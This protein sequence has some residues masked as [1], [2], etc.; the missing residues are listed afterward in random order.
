MLTSSPSS[1]TPSS[2]SMFHQNLVQ[3]G[4]AVPPA[5]LNYISE[6]DNLIYALS[7]LPNVRRLTIYKQLP[8]KDSIPCRE[9]YRLFFPHIGQLFPQLGDL[10]FFSEHVPLETF[11]PRLPRLRKLRFTGFSPTSPTRTLDVLGA[12]K[13]LDTLELVGPPP[14]MSYTNRNRQASDSLDYLLTPTRHR[15]GTQVLLSITPEVVAGL[16]PLKHV[17]IHEIK[18]IYDTTPYHAASHLPPAST[19]SSRS[20][21]T[22]GIFLTSTF[23]SALYRSHV[24]SLISLKIHSDIP[25]SSTTLEALRLLLSTSTTLKELVL[26][27]P[28]PP[29]MDMDYMDLFEHL[30]PSLQK[31]S[32]WVEL[33]PDVLAILAALMKIFVPNTINDNDNNGLNRRVRYSALKKIVLL[34]PIAEPR[35]DRGGASGRFGMY[36]NRKILGSGTAWKS[37]SNH[38]IRAGQNGCTVDCEDSR[39]PSHGENCGSRVL[40]GNT[41]APEEDDDAFQR[42]IDQALA[43]LENAGIKVSVEW[44]RCPS[45]LHED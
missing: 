17:V 43:R 34:V 7:L 6:L 15:H 35:H 26:V 44:G 33:S 29:D 25:L 40:S 45:C 13:F 4:P 39:V 18:E 22:P 9:L 32:L 16:K 38:A 24:S 14:G 23:L 21:T 28:I 19:S 36:Y 27:W 37:L 3:K 42:G 41:C 8:S 31:L 11:L 10:S 2:P 12:L 1:S 30:P 5:A 20:S